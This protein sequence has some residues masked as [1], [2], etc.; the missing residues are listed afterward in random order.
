MKI[1][2]GEGTSNQNTPCRIFF[3]RYFALKAI[4]PPPANLNIDLEEVSMD[5]Y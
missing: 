5:N 3:R 1:S 4:K 2:L